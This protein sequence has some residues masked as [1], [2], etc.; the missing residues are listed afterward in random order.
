LKWPVICLLLLLWGV[1]AVLSMALGGI[2]H[3]FRGAADRLQ[4][5]VE[6]LREVGR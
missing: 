2:G 1:A 4:V 5:A 6:F 3:G